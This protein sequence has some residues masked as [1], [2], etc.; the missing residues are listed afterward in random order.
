MQQPSVS[1]ALL[2]AGLPSV[3]GGRVPTSPVPG[4]RLIPAGEAGSGRA[5]RS[6]RRPGGAEGPRGAIGAPGPRELRALRSKG[7]FKEAL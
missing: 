3:R 2:L 5:L 1:L 6:R 4:P 7:L